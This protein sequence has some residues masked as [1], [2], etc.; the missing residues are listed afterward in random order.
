[1]AT[2]RK[3][4]NTAARAKEAGAKQPQ[5]RQTASEEVDSSIH[6]FNWRGNVYEI[7]IDDLDDLEFGDTLQQSVS[8]GMRI[9]LGGEQYRTLIEDLK[10]NDPK[11]KGKARQTE[12]RRFFE[13]LSEFVRP[14]VD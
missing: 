2:P 10:E 12:M 5:D 7:D 6:E 4:T 3:N 9:L 8:Q 1:M 11:G 13:D 14:L